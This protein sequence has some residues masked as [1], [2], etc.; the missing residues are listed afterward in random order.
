MKRLITVLVIVLLAVLSCS[1]ITAC[2]EKPKVVSTDDDY[3]GTSDENLRVEGMSAF[4]LF[5][6]AYANWLDDKGY[7][8]E[9]TLNFSV[10]SKFLGLMGTRVMQTTRKVDGDRIHNFEITLGDGVTADMTSAKKYYYDGS[11]AYIVTTSEKKNMDFGSTRFSVRQW[12][13]FEPFDGDV[14]SENAF[15]VRR[16]TVYDLTK[17]ESLAKDHN[18][19]V[20]AANGNYYFTLTV[21][22]GIEALK[23][24]QPALL[25][26]YTAN[27][28]ASESTYSMENTTVDVAVR[29][30]DGKMKFVAWYRTETYT[31]KAKDKMEVTCKETC[32]NK[33]TYTGY[34]ITDA[35]LLNLA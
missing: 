9:E 7:L 10:S 34:G 28:S 33:L 30:I 22:C 17:R 4:D 21:D 23:K 6:E 35:E 11:G 16:W 18:D 2:K 31:G 1:L 29:E 12:N 32:Y 5:S 24:Y 26:E 20:Y 8:R 3:L 15:L 25:A 27:M 19:A 14:Q 13:D